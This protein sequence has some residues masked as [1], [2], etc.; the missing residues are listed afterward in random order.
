MISV[1]TNASNDLVLYIFHFDHVISHFSR[2]HV[3]P[4][5]ALQDFAA[6]PHLHCVITG[7]PVSSM[8][9]TRP[10]DSNASARLAT[11]ETSVK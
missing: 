8:S 2:V 9:L 1:N 10:D 3:I 6:C 4:H 11:M 5:P 7:L